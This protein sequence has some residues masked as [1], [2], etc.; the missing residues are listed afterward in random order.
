MCHLVARSSHVC[1]VFAE[2]WICW[3]ST[4]GA[5]LAGVDPAQA[6]FSKWVEPIP[7][8]GFEGLIGLHPHQHFPRLATPVC[9]SASWEFPFAFAW[10]WPRPAFS[11]ATGYLPI[12]LS[13]NYPESLARG[14]C[15]S[16]SLSFLGKKKK[17]ASCQLIFKYVSFIQTCSYCFFFIL[18]LG[19][20]ITRL[21]SW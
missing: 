4:A 2:K 16:L 14:E 7:P 12:I 5:W 11:L 17:K 1:G 15:F 13:Q 19:L 3:D 8:Y 20:Q 21:L 6:Y 18:L 9:S 10:G